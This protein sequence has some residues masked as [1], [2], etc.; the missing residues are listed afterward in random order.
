M[1]RATNVAKQMLPVRKHLERYQHFPPFRTRSSMSG[2]ARCLR[3]GPCGR[4][5]GCKSLRVRQ[6]YLHLTAG[7]RAKVA[8]PRFSYPGGASMPGPP[9]R[10]VGANAL[11]LGPRDRRCKSWRADHFQI[12]AVVEHI[13]HPT[14]NRNDAGGT[15][16]REANVLFGATDLQGL[17]SQSCRQRHCQAV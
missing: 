2:A 5:P 7:Q 16:I 15:A 9:A 12:A 14:S 8:V 3:E 4:P 13:R 10:S 11:G 17:G 1:R 6:F